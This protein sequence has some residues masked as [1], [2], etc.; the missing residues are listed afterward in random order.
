MPLDEKPNAQMDITPTADELKD[1][2]ALA[3]VRLVVGL[4]AVVNAVCQM[5]G[6]QELALTPEMIFALGSAAYLVIQEVWVWWKNNN[7]TKEAV[8]GQKT[9]DALKDDAIP[10]LTVP[11]RAVKA[12]TSEVLGATEVPIDLNSKR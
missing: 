2:R 3:I 11:V 12:A 7:V 6:W 5:I 8:A 1:E 10:S 4:V 9:I